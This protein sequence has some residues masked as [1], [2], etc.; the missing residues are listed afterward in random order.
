MLI[1]AFFSSAFIKWKNKQIENDIEI[2]N[3]LEKKYNQVFGDNTPIQKKLNN[4]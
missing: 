2:V 1:M 3:D 4:N